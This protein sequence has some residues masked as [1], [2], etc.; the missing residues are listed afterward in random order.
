M[1]CLSV[2]N[3]KLKIL[4]GIENY[5]NY[6][7]VVAIFGP[8]KY[9]KG[10][11]GCTGIV[12]RDD[13]VLTAAHCTGIMP[14]LYVYRTPQTEARDNIHDQDL[15]GSPD[16]I[17][18]PGY[19]QTS[20]GTAKTNLDRLR[21]DLARDIAFLVF[22]PGTLANYT[23]AELAKTP[24]KANDSVT[25]VGYGRTGLT[26][27]S[28]PEAK[29]HTGTNTIAAIYPDLAGMIL[30]QTSDVA[31]TQ[32]TALNGDSGGPLFNTDGQVIGI[33]SSGLGALSELSAK[34]KN[35]AT[36]Q[37]L[38]N[39]VKEG[40]LAAATYINIANPGVAKFIARV[41]ADPKPTQE[42]VKD[43]EPIEV[44]NGP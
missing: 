5:S 40:H 29:R 16:Y 3:S 7:S 37:D 26:A 32:A 42:T 34:N 41:M 44:W 35:D 27:A 33:V 18:F 28:N 12:M 24:A 30:V 21:F 13:L 23:K 31:M 25:L 4:G 22:P 11:A 36:G 10:E 39:Y 1:S 17:R 9:R 2:K 38:Q 15:V 14:R 8:P 19:S 6:A 43:V 20:S